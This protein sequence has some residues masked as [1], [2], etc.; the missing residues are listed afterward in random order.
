MTTT[1]REASPAFNADEPLLQRWAMYMRSQNL[2]ERTISER[3]SQA[4]RTALLLQCSITEM[5]EDQVRY[6]VSLVSDPTSRVHVAAQLRA[7]TRWLQDRGIREDDPAAKIR[8]KLPRRSP[9]PCPTPALASMIAH[10]GSLQ[11]RAILLLAAFAGLRVHE[12]AKVHGRDFDL[13]A[14]TLR[15]VGKG[16]VEATVPLH[17][18]L[19]ELARSMPAWDWWFP[20]PVNM[21]SPVHREWVI[22]HVRG[23]ARRAGVKVTAHQL[24]HWC[25][26]YLVRGGTDLRTVQ[27]ILRHASLDTT[28]VYVEVADEMQQAAVRRLPDLGMGPAP[29]RHFPK[30]GE[31][32]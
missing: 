11:M 2:S 23:C 29:T 12:I 10:A 19:I 3:L 14:G 7:C 15:V 16:R 20:S 28:Q 6:R 27:V 25:A 18:D 17:P 32:A 5:D 1:A 8:P 9:R 21:G 13:D 22:R 26:T 30:Y 31:A 24:R 4:R